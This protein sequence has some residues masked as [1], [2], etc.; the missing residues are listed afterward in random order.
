MWQ[1]SHFSSLYATN[2]DG[3]IPEPG[4]SGI[5]EQVYGIIGEKNK[6]ALLISVNFSEVIVYTVITENMGCALLGE[7]YSMNEQ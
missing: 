5:K 6:F 3:A 7:F 4:K 1:R 2:A